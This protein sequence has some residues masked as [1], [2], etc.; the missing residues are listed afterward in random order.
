MK[1][2]EGYKIEVVL[3]KTGDQEFKKGK[4][5]TITRD[6]VLDGNY[7]RIIKDALINVASL[8]TKEIDEDLK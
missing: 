5:I 4:A 7:K 2:A 1:V 3:T 6:L 8:V